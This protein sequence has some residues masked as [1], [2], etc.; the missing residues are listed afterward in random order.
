MKTFKPKLCG[1]FLGSLILG[2][3]LSSCI[4]PDQPKKPVDLISENNYVD[5]LVDMQHIITWRNVKQDSV[6]ADSLKQVIYDR[7]EITEQQFEA[8]HTYYQQQVERQLV[9]IE[10][11]LRRLEG[12]SSYIET[13]I[14][15]VKKL[16]QASD[17]LDTDES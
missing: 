7:Y 5:L 10:E 4:S 17:S 15:S 12:E 1:L 9:R 3:I 2:G 8:S 16:K 14:D 13:H 11:V 6:N